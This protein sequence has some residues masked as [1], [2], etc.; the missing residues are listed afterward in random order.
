MPCPLI[1][2]RLTA[3][4]SGNIFVWG[5]FDQ[6]LPGMPPHGTHLRILRVSGLE[7][8]SQPPAYSSYAPPA[9]PL[10]D[11]KPGGT[12]PPSGTYGKQGGGEPALPYPC[13]KGQP[14]FDP[15]QQ[16]SYTQTSDGHNAYY[17]KKKKSCCIQ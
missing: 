6:P 5:D 14:G 2:P 16:G 17:P 7:T 10:L 13:Y 3:C 8:V 1:E 12:N 4:H 15:N 9:N 11:N